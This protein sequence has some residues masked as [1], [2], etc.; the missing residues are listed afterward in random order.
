MELYGD[1]WLEMRRQELAREWTIWPENAKGVGTREIQDVARSLGCEPS[2]NRR[3][4]LR[5][6]AEAVMLD[7]A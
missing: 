5:D 2:M 7:S 1:E 3:K 6:I 4:M